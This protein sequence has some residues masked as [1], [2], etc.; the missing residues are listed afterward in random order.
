VCVASAECY[1][2][3][4]KYLKIFQK[5]FTET[6]SGSIEVGTIKKVRLVAQR[7]QI[8]RPEGYTK[9]NQPHVEGKPKSSHLP[10]LSHSPP[11]KWEGGCVR[12]TTSPGKLA[13]SKYARATFTAS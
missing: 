7:F 4:Q 11:E 3:Y 9:W 10:L 2:P 8:I 6:T 5:C 1:V 12:H 13:F